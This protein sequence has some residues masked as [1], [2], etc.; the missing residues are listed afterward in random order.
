MI[1]AGMK[2]VSIPGGKLGDLEKIEMIR[3]VESGAGGGI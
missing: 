1:P 2:S 3:C